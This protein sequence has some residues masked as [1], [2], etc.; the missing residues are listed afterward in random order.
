MWIKVVDRDI[1]KMEKVLHIT[2]FNRCEC[3]EEQVAG[4]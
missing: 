1:S 2:G 3:N 4:I